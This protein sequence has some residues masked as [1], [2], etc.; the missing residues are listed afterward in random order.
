MWEQQ[1]LNDVNIYAQ[2]EAMVALGHLRAGEDIMGTLSDSVVSANT[3]MMLQGGGGGGAAPSGQG[4]GGTTATGSGGGGGGGSYAIGAD[5]LVH[6]AIQ[7]LSR[8]LT[9]HR[10]HPFLRYGK[11]ELRRG[12]EDDEDPTGKRET[13]RLVI[14][15]YHYRYV[16]VENRRGIGIQQELPMMYLIPPGLLCVVCNVILSRWQSCCGDLGQLLVFFSH[17][18]PC[19]YSQK[20]SLSLRSTRVCLLSSCLPLY[21]STWTTLCIRRE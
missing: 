20:A 18:T 11:N 16:P 15:Q 4:G 7:S 2:L 14:P 8:G 6:D 12:E 21:L 9:C 17:V 3:M 5:T 1:L 19:S 10:W 13:I